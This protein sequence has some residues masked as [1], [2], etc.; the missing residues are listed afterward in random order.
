MLLFSSATGRLVQRYGARPCAACGA[1]I[2]GIGL[3]AASTARS[4]PLLG[5][6]YGGVAGVGFA[7]AWAPSSVVAGAYFTGARLAVASGIAVSGSG[8]GTIVLAQ[9]LPPPNMVSCRN[10]SACKR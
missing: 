4:L 2:S 10:G 1:I 3:A 7:L 8:V 9:V 6:A 5:L